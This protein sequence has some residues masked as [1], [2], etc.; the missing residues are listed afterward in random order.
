VFDL[1]AR[2]PLPVR[3]RPLVVMDATLLGYLGLSLEE[4]A[5]V[6]RDIVAVCRRHRGDAVV[7]YHND[8]LWSPRRQAHYRELVAEI[9]GG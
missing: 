5:S 3:E 4:A 1:L 7:L 6:A 2:R 9:M 8:S